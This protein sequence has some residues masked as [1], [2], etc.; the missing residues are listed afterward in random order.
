M[1]IK[2]FKHRGP[3]VSAVNYC[4]SNKDH[5]GKTREVKP[6]ILK[7]DAS[8]TKSLDAITAKYSVQATSGVISFRDSENLTEDQKQKLIDDFEDCF[9]G[10]D[11]KDKVNCLY[12]EHRDKGNLEIHFII[13]N[14][15]IDTKP[16]YFNPFPPGHQ[17][18]KDAFVSK[19]NH[20]YGF[21][22][23]KQQSILSQHYSQNEKKAIRSKKENGKEHGFYNLK[24]KSSIHKLLT[25]EIKK[26]NI[27]NR[28]ELIK[29]LK[30]DLGLELSRIGKNYISIKSK[31]KDKAN[32]RLKG[33]I[34]TENND[35]SYKLLQQELNA[36][37][38]S[39][40]I[41]K[42]NKSFIEEKNKRIVFNNKRYNTNEPI[43]APTAQK[44]SLPVSITTPSSNNG[45]QP[46][47]EPQ[48]IQP[49]EQAQQ[50]TTGGETLQL[51]TTATSQL[52]DALN[53]L[54]NARTPE[55]TSSAQMAVAR[56]KIAVA[57]EEAENERR[58]QQL[59]AQAEITKRNNLNKIKLT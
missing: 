31:D 47:L 23:I 37:N 30:E 49:I 45:T 20:E 1:I 13:N 54:A 28:T 8:Y 19:K 4:L 16:K 17:K 32:I 34:Y 43:T 39:F 56:A 21:E 42:V 58:K 50:S 29:F 3:S 40:D 51:S 2:L 41:D 14:V 6:K 27:N 18:L 25:E 24:T 55:Q 52:A 53:Q 33:D 35:K 59:L 57:R 38:N 44:D 48:S 11:L 7:G 5:A 46:D 10:K 36:K 15:V 9:I 26:G 12:I 22:Q